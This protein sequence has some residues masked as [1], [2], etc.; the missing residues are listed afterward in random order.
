MNVI[1]LSVTGAFVLLALVFASLFRSLFSPSRTAI[2]ADW[3]INQIASRYRAMERLLDPADYRFLQS[4]PGYGRR[5]ARRLRGQRVE[6]FRS[7]ARCLKRDFMR[8][9]GAL[10][11]LM[12]HAPVDR[13]SLA[14]ILVK[15]R[16]LFGFNM[17][18]V[19]I[20]L[21]LHSFGLTAPKVDVRSLVEALDAMRTQLQVLAATAQPA[22]SAA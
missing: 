18:S 15:Q 20:R 17:M 16:L 12:V 10:R 5:M 2:P 22:A 8:V 11:M 6:I 21:V 13:S 9:S 3:D 1:L 19:E 7:Y 14:G 4:A